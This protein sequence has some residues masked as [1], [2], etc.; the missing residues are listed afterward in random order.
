MC[1]KKLNCGLG[2][3]GVNKAFVIHFLLVHVKSALKIIIII[4]GTP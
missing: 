1:L 3:L 4:Q 2:V